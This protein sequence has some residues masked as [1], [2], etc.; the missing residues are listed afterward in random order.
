MAVTI[1]HEGCSVAEFITL[2]EGLTQRGDMLLVKFS[3][4][5][6]KPCRVI[7]PACQRIFSSMSDKVYILEI[8]VDDSI[9]LV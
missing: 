8:D 9:E 6:C 2:R 1:E 7:A 4:S 3:A 5:W